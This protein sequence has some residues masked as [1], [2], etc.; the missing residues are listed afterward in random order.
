MNVGELRQLLAN[1]DQ[2]MPVILS[3]DA[4][5]NEFKHV[6]D[7]ETEYWDD[8]DREVIHPED[9][10]DHRELPPLACVLWPV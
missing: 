10:E 1:L 2:D 8:E 5:G 7:V 3:K 9:I 4:E 6:A